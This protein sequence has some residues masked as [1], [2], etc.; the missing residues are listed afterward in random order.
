MEEV[1]RGDTEDC[2]GLITTTLTPAANSYG[3]WLL[4]GN[5]LIKCSVQA[6]VCL[7][8]YVCLCVTGVGVDGGC[9]GGSNGT[10]LNP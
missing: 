10:F 9:S 1:G 7:S 2:T 8:E 4:S 6:H 3:M 5:A